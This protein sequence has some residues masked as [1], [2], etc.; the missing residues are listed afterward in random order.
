[1]RPNVHCAIWNAQPPFYATMPLFER[2]PIEQLGPYCTP[3]ITFEMISFFTSSSSFSCS[4]SLQYIFKAICQK[5]EIFSFSFGVNYI[6][7]WT[8]MHTFFF[9]TAFSPT[10]RVWWHDVQ[11]FASNCL[12]IKPL[13]TFS[14]HILRE[15]NFIGHT[16][17]ATFRLIK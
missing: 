2:W 11:E 3:T 13:D 1:M 5:Y 9:S 10:N 4:F 15:L 6:I 17:L 16:S 14:H 12:Q 8:A 7:I